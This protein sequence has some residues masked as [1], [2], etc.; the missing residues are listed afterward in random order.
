LL[1]SELMA[2]DQERRRLGQNGPER[3]AEVSNYQRMIAEF[4]ELIREAAR[5]TDAV[6]AELASSI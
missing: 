6:S 3:L 4:S 5:T 2:S 1:L